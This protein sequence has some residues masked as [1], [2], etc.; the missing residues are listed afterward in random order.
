MYGLAAVNAFG[1]HFKNEMESAIESELE[2]W[3]LE[4]RIQAEYD[5]LMDEFDLTYDDDGNII[6]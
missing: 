2:D 5:S 1:R 4:D 3:P 6:D